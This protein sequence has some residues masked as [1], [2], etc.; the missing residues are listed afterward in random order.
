M[1]AEELRRLPGPYEILDLG[2]GETARLRVVSWE[3][4]TIVIHPKWPGAPP[5]KE[6]VVLRTHLAAGVKPYPPLYYDITSKTLQAQLLPM[7]ME[8]GFERYWYVI[9]KHGVPPRAR[10]TLE[11]RPI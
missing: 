2:D 11:R 1:M 8:R 4:G 3:R 6:I 5:E 7:L 9:T 10:F